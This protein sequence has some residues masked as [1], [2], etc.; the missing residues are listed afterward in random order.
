MQQSE[1]RRILA[2]IPAYNE[3]RHIAPVIEQTKKFLPVLVVDDGSKDDTAL[4]AEAAGAEVL[5]QMPNKGKGA[6]LMAGFRRAVDLGYDALVMLDA[7]GQH[8]PQEIPAFLQAFAETG[9]D[10]IIGQRD[11]RYMPRLRRTTNT[12]GTWVFSWAVGQHIPD[13]QSGFRL[14]S[15]RMME[16][17]LKSRE[18]NFEF[19]VEMIVDCIRYGYKLGWVKIRT[20]YG[21]ETSHIRPFRHAVHFVRMM[22]QSRLAVRRKVKE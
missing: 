12:F 3:G 22:I 19:E 15:R 21:D 20:I 8:D 7:D 9:A 13:N 17:S 4:Q 10:L 2:L 16:A 11:F 18:T 1:N 14:L 5:R 6:A